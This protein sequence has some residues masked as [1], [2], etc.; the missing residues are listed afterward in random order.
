[1]LFDIKTIPKVYTGYQ[2]S[3]NDNFPTGC[4]YMGK[5]LQEF[6]LL[7]SKLF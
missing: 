3:V 4:C 5:S 7:S 2:P 1:M 6:C